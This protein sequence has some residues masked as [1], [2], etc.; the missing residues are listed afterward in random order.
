MTRNAVTEQVKWTSKREK[1]MVKEVRKRMLAT[2]PER[3]GFA[4]AT[5]PALIRA[6]SKAKLCQ[7]RVVNDGVERTHG[8]LFRERETLPN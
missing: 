1:S 6:C 5:G 8:S 3:G 7:N 4:P 2:A